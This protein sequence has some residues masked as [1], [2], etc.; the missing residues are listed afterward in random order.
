MARRVHGSGDIFDYQGRRP[1]SS[2]NFVAAH[3]G[4]TLN[5]LVSFN[6][7]HNEANGE[8]NK[9]GSGYN[10]SWNCGAEGP[11]ED[12]AIN[13]LRQRQ[14]RNF[15]ATLFCSQ[16]L[17]MLLAGDEFGRTQ[18]GNNNAYCQD[19]EIGWLDWDLDD[20]S[21]ATL[22][23]TRRL[24][25]LRARH[26]ALRYGRF[27]GRSDFPDNPRDLI[28]LTPEAV[29]MDHAAWEDPGA[30]AFGMLIDVPPVNGDERD[31]VLLA[32]NGG[33]DEVEMTLPKS[34]LGGTWRRV[35]DTGFDH[36][37]PETAEAVYP[38]AGRSVVL[39]EAT[40]PD[41]VVPS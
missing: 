12:A 3:D 21:E 19:S 25:D 39:F 34:P 41:E 17:P 33:A 29:E 37:E 26:P 23:F 30:R 31:V 28:W 32:F 16:G 24:T 5:D 7:K 14:I 18:G 10:R 38:L 8:D 35:L 2:V 27:L 36:D 1:R 20:R 9:D 40:P 15:L 11:T 4:F 13:A 6:D 22:R